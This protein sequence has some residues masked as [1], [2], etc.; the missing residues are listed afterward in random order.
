VL[1]HCEE[2]SDEAIQLVLRD[3]GLLRSARNDAED[4]QRHRLYIYVLPKKRPEM[5]PIPPEFK[6]L[7]LQFQLASLSYFGSPERMIASTLTKFGDQKRKV[8]KE[9]VSD[10]LS[11][12]YD[13]EEISDVWHSTGSDFFFSNNEQLTSHQQ[14]TSFLR[15]IQERV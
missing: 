11:E 5:I 2:R 14:L 3:P 10:L 4:I 8:I 13:K 9:F 15:L 7:C 12:K 6:E 1:R